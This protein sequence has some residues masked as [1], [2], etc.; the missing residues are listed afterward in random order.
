MQHRS[1]LQRPRPAGGAPLGARGA[2]PHGLV[3]LPRHLPQLVQHDGAQELLVD[4]LLHNLL[5]GP[6]LACSGS[7]EV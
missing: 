5:Q 2:L 1:R 7:K 6:Q 4:E 3:G